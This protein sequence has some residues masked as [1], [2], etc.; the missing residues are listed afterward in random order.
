M[1]DARKIPN[2][3]WESHKKTIEILY[4]TQ[5]K[6]LNEV[7]KAME[8]SHEFDARLVTLLTPVVACRT[9]SSLI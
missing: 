8:E 9:G 5:N 1:E 7:M 2:S 3:E 4:L 6:S